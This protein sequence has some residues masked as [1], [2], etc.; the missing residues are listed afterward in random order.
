MSKFPTPT[1]HFWNDAS[2][3]KH[4]TNIH[5][6]SVCSKSQQATS[7]D[8]HHYSTEIPLPEGGV[9]QQSNI[10]APHDWT[11]AKLSHVVSVEETKTQRPQHEHTEQRHPPQTVALW[12][13]TS[14]SVWLECSPEAAKEHDIRFRCEH[15][16]LLHTSIRTTG[17][18]HKS[19]L[20]ALHVEASCCSNQLNIICLSYCPEL[21]LATVLTG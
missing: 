15:W 17:M 4:C 7:F 14:R 11:R 10:T 18:C 16:D 21:V 12:W 1:Q 13:K 9:I 3:R 8:V 19:T 20:C 6:D 5:H 2:G